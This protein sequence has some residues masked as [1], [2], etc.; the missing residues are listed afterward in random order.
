MST[1]SLNLI[2]IDDQQQFCHV[3]FVQK[4]LWVNR[5]FLSIIAQE[6]I[7]NFSKHTMQLH[8]VTAFR[9]RT[10]TY[11]IL[12]LLEC[13]TKVFF[14]FALLLLYHYNRIHINSLPFLKRRSGVSGGTRRGW[15]GSPSLLLH[16]CRNWLR[17]HRCLENLS[18]K[19][20]KITIVINNETVLSSKLPFFYISTSPPP[21]LNTTLL[22]PSSLVSHQSSHIQ[23][24]TK[25]KLCDII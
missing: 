18:K 6:M 2:T 12:V 22:S 10:C 13:A 15:W 23:V 25:P 19:K 11:G 7:T 16:F 24:T 14:C 1:W 9:R 3:L 4:C 21:V 5:K 8:L 20:K 17:I